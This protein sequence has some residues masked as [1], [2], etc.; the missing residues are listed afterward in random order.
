MAEFTKSNNEGSNEEIPCTERECTTGSG[1]CWKFD[2]GKCAKDK[3]GELFH[4]TN[5]VEAEVLVMEDLDALDWTNMKGQRRLKR[6]L[7]PNNRRPS[8][9]MVFRLMRIPVL[10]GRGGRLGGESNNSWRARIKQE[11]LAMAAQDAHVGLEDEKHNTKYAIQPREFVQLTPISDG[12]V[13]GNYEQLLRAAHDLGEE[14][15]DFHIHFYEANDPTHWS[16]VMRTLDNNGVNREYHIDWRGWWGQNFMGSG[17]PIRRPWGRPDPRRFLRDAMEALANHV[18]TSINTQIGNATRPR[19]SKDH[20][21][22]GGGGG[23]GKYGGGGDDGGGKY[24]GGG[25]DGGGKYGGGGDD[26]GIKGGYYTHHRKRRAKKKKTRRRSKRRRKRKT[27]RKRRR[28]RR[29]TRR[30]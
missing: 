27:R 4:C 24:G 26:G 29:R 13:G 30:H 14:I 3:D 10:G 7:F 25:D 17:N 2:C 20:G 28:R 12:H 6:L 5:P 21:G 11:L 19:Y 18:G 9:R 22:G 15:F 23:G 1:F 16:I 8:N